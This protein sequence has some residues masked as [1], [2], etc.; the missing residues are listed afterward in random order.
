MR[1][2]NRKDFGAALD[3][4]AMLGDARDLDDFGARL[5]G[6]LHTVINCSG[7]SYNETNL[8]RRRIRWI[9]DIEAQPSAKE[10][11]EYHIPTNPMVLHHAR[12][13][14][15][16]AVTISDLISERQWHNLGV[17][18]D[19]YRPHR[20]E[21]MLSAAPLVASTLIAVAAF[22]DR[23]DFAA[24]DR[25]MLTLLNPHMASAYR[26]SETLADLGNRLALFESG[27]STEGIGLILLVRGERVD[28]VSA[29]AR[30]WLAKYFDHRGNGLPD[31]ILEWLRRSAIPGSASLIMPGPQTFSVARDSAR[32]MLRLVGNGGRRLIL[33]RERR[34][35]NPEDL[36]SLGLTKRESEILALVAGE[37]TDADIAAVLSLSPRTVNNVL[38]RI[39][40]KLNVHNR[41][42]AVAHAFDRRIG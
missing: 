2:L 13:V 42:G 6:G 23:T 30:H 29:K 28:L 8:R 24:R 39:Y 36:Q 3:F 19:V 7:V 26:H 18:A 27:F 32:L 33:L 22:R 5:V 35:L 15:A 17:Y 37:K 31:T 9:T 20:M 10:A 38:A 41:A 12:H 34:P 21:K 1:N 16:D 11:F 25:A 14:G 4:I 40:R